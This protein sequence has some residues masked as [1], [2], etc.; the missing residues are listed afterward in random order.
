M[1][2]GGDFFPACFRGRR[3]RRAYFPRAAVWSGG[4]G[5][6]LNRRGNRTHYGIVNAARPK[7]N[8]KV[9]LSVFDLGKSL[10]FLGKSGFELG[11]KIISSVKSD[12]FLDLS[13]SDLGKS[14]DLLGKSR[15]DLG[16]KIISLV[17]KEVSLG[18]SGSD[19]PKSDADLGKKM[20][21]FAHLKMK[22]DEKDRV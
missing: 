8:C 6:A 2:G 1:T 18:K 11:K 3:T 22:L 7:A 14:D 21:Q 9:P 16:K 13:G 4:S 10:G 17:K 19:L 5:S 12:V 20:P 15:F